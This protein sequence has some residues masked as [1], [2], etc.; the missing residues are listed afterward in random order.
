[1]NKDRVYKFWGSGNEALSGLRPLPESAF[2][3]IE[4]PYDLY[5]A[6]RQVWCRETCAPRLQEK[7]SEENPTLGQCSI[8]SFLT[9]DIFGGDVYGVLR[10]GGNYH[11]YNIVDGI[12]FDLTS[13]QFGTE[14]LDYS[15]GEK[16]SRKVHFQKHEKQERYIFLR[17]RLL[18]YLASYCKN[19]EKDDRIDPKVCM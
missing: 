18:K 1:M 8:T 16:Q 4:D 5:D 12:A 2:G 17:K 13:E 7:W 9:Q 11:C 10:P 19:G 6:L 15:K 3:G 14:R